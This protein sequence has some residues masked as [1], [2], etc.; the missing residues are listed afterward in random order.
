MTLPAY[1]E[2]YLLSVSQFHILYIHSQEQCLGRTTG[3]LQMIRLKFM[4]TSGGLP[5]ILEESIEYTSNKRKQTWKMSTCNRIT[6]ILTDYAQESGGQ[7]VREG[8]FKVE[9]S[10][11]DRLKEFACCLG[12]VVAGEFLFP[13][14]RILGSMLCLFKIIP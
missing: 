13:C 11:S 2:L 14:K 3:S 5:I 4:E 6:R 9:E 10:I 8:I 7:W 12:G 1:S